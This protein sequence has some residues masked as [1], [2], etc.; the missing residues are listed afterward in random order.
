M[1]IGTP[2]RISKFLGVNTKVIPEMIEDQESSVIFNMDFD[3]R[4]SLRTRYGYASILTES[5][6]TFP[7]N[8]IY[9]YKKTGTKDQVIF[10]SGTKLYKVSNSV[11]SQIY[12][13]VDAKS[14]VD[15]EQFQ[16]KL[17]FADAKNPLRSWDGNIT[18]SNITI[19]DDMRPQYLVVHKDRMFAC[20]GKTGFLYYCSLENP[21]NWNSPLAGGTGGLISIT[22]S[23]DVITGLDI[24]ADSIIVFTR[25]TI[26]LL[27]IDGDPLTDW[28][29]RKTNSDVG[30][31]N[32]F[33]IVP[34]NN[35]LFFLSERG[36]SIFT[37]TRTSDEVLGNA[38]SFDDFGAEQLSEKIETKTRSD[39]FALFDFSWANAVATYFDFKYILCVS[40]TNK[41][42]NYAFVLDI[43][44]SS[45]TFYENYKFNCFAKGLLDNKSVLFAGDSNEG[46]VYEIRNSDF[47]YTDDNGKPI[48]SYFITKAFNFNGLE[49]TK[50]FRRT[51]VS[52]FTGGSAGIWY[53][54][55][56]DFKNFFNV[57]YPLRGVKSGIPIW[58]GIT[59]DA[60]D[61][62]DFS[63]WASPTDSSVIE[64]DIPHIPIKGRTIRFKF[65]NFTEDQEALEDYPNERIRPF[66]LYH[67]EH[68]YKPRRAR[69][70]LKG[71]N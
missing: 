46:H 69:N 64:Q 37:G 16:D 26:Y 23:N 24:L 1:V 33:T 31:I 63:T 47:P 60:T 25:K 15:F 48:K 44:R 32:G 58:A 10:K 22:R 2:V 70:I 40:D 29:L 59:G 57:K 35:A 61:P 11:S 9:V 20:D 62:W 67:L 34:V 30:C 13:N 7:V 53:S 17:F 71:G 19:P 21:T 54:Y 6:G 28:V 42:N 51:F 36:V 41:T 18:I 12:S 68:Y 45:W 5:I 66:I 43:R 65:A 8:G 56:S 14:K 3:Y 49:M 4:D 27:Y 50:E 52:Y 38:L 55:S 39:Q